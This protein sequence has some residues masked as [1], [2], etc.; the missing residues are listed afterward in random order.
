LPEH[1]AQFSL[2]PGVGA[3][4]LRLAPETK[5]SP[6]KKANIVLSAHGASGLQPLF[7]SW[8]LSVCGNYIA[9]Q[10]HLFSSALQMEADGQVGASAMPA[11]THC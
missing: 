10:V 11:F 3:I 9:K 6:D 1:G 5:S 4:F 8:N 7:G 2:P